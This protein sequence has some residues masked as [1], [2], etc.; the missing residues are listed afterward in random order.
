MALDGGN[1]EKFHESFRNRHQKEADRLRHEIEDLVRQAKILLH[2]PEPKSRLPPRPTGGKRAER[3]KELEVTLEKANWYRHEI[4]KL[5]RD[6][7][8]WDRVSNFACNGATE[9]DPMETYNLLVEKRKELH[10]LQRNG[11]GL[12]RVV[13]AQR[14]AEAE[15]NTLSPDIEDRLHRAKDE[16]EQQKRLNIKLQADRQKL[17][18]ARKQAEQEVR[19][20][21]GELKRKEAQ[22]QRP[23][24]A[25]KPV[26][27][28]ES[29]EMKQLR[30]DVDILVEAVRQDERKHKVSQRDDEQ[31]VELTR[32]AVA[33]ARSEVAAH[34]AEILQLRA[35]LAGDEPLS[36]H[37]ILS[38][39]SEVSH[40]RVEPLVHP[41][42]EASA[43]AHPAML[44]PV[45]RPARNEGL[46][47]DGEEADDMAPLVASP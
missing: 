32:R 21:T 13:A 39:C 10:R 29:K 37:R 3:E 20:A 19:A 6:L 25:A 26:G 31:Q 35:A 2:G 8:S 43:R 36:A 45:G 9:R 28:G 14:R 5:R 15:Q 33:K 22:L 40:G 17:T 1:P 24:R 42:P 47:A 27:N 46:E 12:D 30:R 34:E 23:P 38:P 18:V 7:E 16:V 11:H 4:K 44:A 41:E